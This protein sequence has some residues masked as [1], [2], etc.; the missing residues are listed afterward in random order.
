MKLPPIDISMLERDFAQMQRRGVVYGYGSKAPSLACDLS[1]IKAIDCSGYARLALYRASGGALVIPD[2]SQMQRAFFEDAA[3]E[4]L[5]RGVGYSDAARYM[6]DSR[7]FIAFIKPFT[8]GCGSVGHV[9]LL[10]KYDDGNNGT[11]AGT[12]ESHGGGGINSRA[13]NNRTLLREVYSCFELG[14]K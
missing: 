4:G 7:L 10:S 8:N 13:W 11:A 3:R 14:T 12:L 9:W 6:N 1:R 5:V 2:G